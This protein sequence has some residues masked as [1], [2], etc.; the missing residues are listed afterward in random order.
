MQI[1]RYEIPFSVK[2]ML[3]FTSV[4]FREEKGKK[5]LKSIILLTL[6]DFDTLSEKTQKLN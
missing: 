3:L 5:L 4:Y 1:A 2:K 6:N